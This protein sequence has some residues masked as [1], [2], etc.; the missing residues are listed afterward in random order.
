MQSTPN[1]ILCTCDQLRAFEVGCYGNPVVQTPNV[2]RLA[3]LRR[4]A[5]GG[6]PGHP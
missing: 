6:D 1:I 5:R 4:D 3:A 2:D